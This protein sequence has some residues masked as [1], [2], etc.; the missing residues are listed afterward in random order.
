MHT[1]HHQQTHTQVFLTQIN[2]QGGF[3]HRLLHEHTYLS[4]AMVCDILLVTNRGYII[5]S[6]S[7]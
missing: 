3:I 5:T 4:H 1:N 7:H 6:N 2:I